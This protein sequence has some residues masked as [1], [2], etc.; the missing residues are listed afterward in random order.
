MGIHR[1]RLGVKLLSSVFL[2]WGHQNQHR[3]A[4][5]WVHPNQDGGLGTEPEPE[6]G[7][8]GTVFFQEPK[9]E[10]ELPKQVLL[11]V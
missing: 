11:F 8:V 7:T 1:G 2:E 6:T 9:E 3:T 10:P 5:S 4:N